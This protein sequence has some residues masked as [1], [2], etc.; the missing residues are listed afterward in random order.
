MVNRYLFAGLSALALAPAAVAQSF[1]V[2][3]AVV[4]KAD[5]EQQTLAVKQTLTRFEAVT[6]EV[7]VVID[8]RIV[9]RRVTEMV[10]VTAEVMMTLHLKGMK[11]YTG[12]GKAIGEKDLWDRLKAGSAVVLGDERLLRP[13]F[14]GTFRAEALLLIG[15]APAAP[16]PEKR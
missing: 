3:L 16:A 10:P 4:E 14:A 13:P 15:P 9:K 2:T 1:T 6:R 12:D 8:G 7:E 11:G 5:R